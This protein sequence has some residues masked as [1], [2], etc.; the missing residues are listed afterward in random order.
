V[1]KLSNLFEVRYIDEMFLILLAV[2]EN[3]AP[4]NIHYLRYTALCKVRPILTFY[5]LH[6]SIVQKKR[7]DN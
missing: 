3:S 2:N 5:A 1:K 6:H 4:T 7:H